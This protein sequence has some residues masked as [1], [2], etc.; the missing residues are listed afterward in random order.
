MQI[1]RLCVIIKTMLYFITNLHSGRRAYSTWKKLKKYLIANNIQYKLLL[2]DYEVHAGILASRIDCK[3]DNDVKV[4]VVGNDGAIN[5]VVNGID[6]FTKIKFGVIPNG[7]GND[8]VRG[9]HIK[10]HRFHPEKILEKILKSDGARK[11]DVGKVTIDDGT[12]RYFAVSSGVGLDAIVCKKTFT[13]KLKKVLKFLH[14]SGLIYILTTVQT[15]FSM[16][17]YQVRVKFDDEEEVFYDRLIFIAGMNSLVEGG[18]VKMA[19]DA[20]TDD[21]YLNSCGVN[22][23]PKVLTFFAFPFLIMGLHTKFKSFILHKFTKMELTSETKMVLHTDGEYA[24]DI[25]HITMQVIPA[26]LSLLN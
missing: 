2:S 4:I 23:I 9:N 8:F 7:S 24:G 13:S 21:G 10:M 18:G 5:E 16:K 1:L 15:L 22:G 12:S 3:N 26:S 19:P 25:E 14:L 11:I 17:R 20:E 6:D